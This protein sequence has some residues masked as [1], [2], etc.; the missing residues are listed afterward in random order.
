MSGGN[1]WHSIG[2]LKLS[3]PRMSSAQSLG[4]SSYF[5][6]A[7]DGADQTI[8]FPPLHIHHQNIMSDEGPMLDHT[9]DFQC[10]S[11]FEYGHVKS[12]TECFTKT[13]GR[14]VL[15]IKSPLFASMLVN[16]VRPANSSSMFWLY[17]ISLDFQLLFQCKNQTHLGETQRWCYGDGS[18]A[19]LMSVHLLYNNRD[20]QVGGPA[21]FGSFLLKSSTL[22]SFIFYV[23]RMPRSGTLTNYTWLHAHQ[24]SHQESFLLSATVPLLS[25]SWPNHYMP[26]RAIPTRTTTFMNSTHLSGYLSNHPGLVCR[27]KGRVELVAG[28]AYDRSAQKICSAWTF[29]TGQSFTAVGL[30]APNATTRVFQHQ[31]WRLFYV[32]G[33]YGRTLFGMASKY[34]G[35]ASSCGRSNITRSDATVCASVFACT[36]S[37]SVLGLSNSAPEL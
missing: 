11:S 3:Q 26:C 9:G 5:T 33:R 25:A 20:R 8:G 35:L 28:I 1:D 4:L 12:G 30:Y 16:D 18:P 24:T 17:K 32:D 29:Q 21:T 27:S 10:P 2:F 34:C 36:S 37:V 31:L 23:G 19:S 7:V 13:F 6:G 22:P 15:R 14:N